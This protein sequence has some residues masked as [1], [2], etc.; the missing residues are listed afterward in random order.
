VGGRFEDGGAPG[1]FFFSDADTL[2]VLKIFY[3]GPG[4]C[5]SSGFFLKTF[6]FFFL[7]FSG[8]FSV[9][10]FSPLSLIALH[11]SVDLLLLPLF[12]GKSF[13]SFSVLFAALVNNLFDLFFPLSTPH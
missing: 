12:F 7:P 8:F 3:S 1:M 5:V 2:D 10:C 11:F 6:F 4:F 9:G 13:P